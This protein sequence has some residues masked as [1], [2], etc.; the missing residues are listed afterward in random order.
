MF[1]PEDVDQIEKETGLN[2][3]QIEHWAENL[4]WRIKSNIFAD[5]VIPYLESNQNVHKVNRTTPINWN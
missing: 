5:G 3:A 4:R 1:T 2:S